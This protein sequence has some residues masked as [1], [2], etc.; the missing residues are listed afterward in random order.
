MNNIIRPGYFPAEQV[1]GLNLELGV[2]NGLF[3]IKFGRM[4]D[5]IVFTVNEAQQIRDTLNTYIA[6][7]IKE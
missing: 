1:E 6:S 3:I 4:V 5:H 2:T 7:R